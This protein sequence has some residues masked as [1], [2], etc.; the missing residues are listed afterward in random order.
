MSGA[1]WR[2]LAITASIVAVGVAVLPFL[3]ARLDLLLLGE[4]EA[5]HLGV[6]VKQVRLFAFGATSL[7]AGAAVAAAGIVGFV[8]LVAPHAV[9]AVLGPAHRRLVLASAAAGAIFVMAADLVARTVATP[10]EA[11]LGVVTAIVGG[12]LFLWLLRRTRAEYG[13]WG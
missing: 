13:E 1:T 9:R 3:A 12:P 11:P 7:I 8:G 10:T 4:R 6:D 5:A 2:E